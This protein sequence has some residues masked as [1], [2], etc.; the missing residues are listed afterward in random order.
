MNVN[1]GLMVGMHDEQEAQL[2]PRHLLFQ[3]TAESTTF[4]RL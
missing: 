3:C 1:F 2:I 4:Q